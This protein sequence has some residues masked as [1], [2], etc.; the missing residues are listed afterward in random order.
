[1]GV[2][3]TWVC[4]CIAMHIVQ[5]VYIKYLCVI[6]LCGWFDLVEAFI[7]TDCGACDDD[8]DV[9]PSTPSISTSFTLASPVFWTNGPPLSECVFH[10]ILSH[11]IR[12][13]TFFCLFGKFH[14]VQIYIVV[15]VTK[16]IRRNP[17]T[18][19]FFWFISLLLVS[20]FHLRCRCFVFYNRFRFYSIRS[21]NWFFHS[22]MKMK[23]KIDQK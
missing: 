2:E 7:K 16:V 3:Q 8:D 11:F 1:M 9:H 23:E 15:V 17:R 5:T 20:P 22:K 14:S 13:L 10:S 18:H 12:C 19:Y 4:V 21:W 6:L